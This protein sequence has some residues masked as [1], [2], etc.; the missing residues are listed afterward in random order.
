MVSPITAPFTC[1]P[2]QNSTSISSKDLFINQLIA[3]N[4]YSILRGKSTELIQQLME[5]AA[6]EHTLSGS[7]KTEFV[8]GFFEAVINAILLPK[9]CHIRANVMIQSAPSQIFYVKSLYNAKDSL[10]SI[11]TINYE[12]MNKR[13]R[14]IL[15]E[16]KFQMLILNFQNEIR[17]YNIASVTHSIFVFTSNLIGIRNEER[18]HIQNTFFYLILGAAFPDRFLKEE[19]MT[20]Y[21]ACLLLSLA[22]IDLYTEAANGNI[23][24]YDCTR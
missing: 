12:I 16:N 2:G 22:T 13:E 5:L 19:E 6:K 14:E 15:I 1:H 21:D 18:K 4:N 20:A 8:M 24:L 10:S 3:K 23:L 7:E 9:E 11:H 17:N